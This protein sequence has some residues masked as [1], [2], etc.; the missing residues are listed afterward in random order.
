MS[1]SL[2]GLGTFWVSRRFSLLYPN[3]W[4]FRNLF[5]IIISFSHTFFSD[6]VLLPNSGTVGGVSG[7][8]L[9]KLSRSR[10]CTL[11]NHFVLNYGFV[12]STMEQP[13]LL[14]QM[15]RS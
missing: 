9:A 10:D 4:A 14:A 5:P 11:I 7:T 1:S 8:Y 6:T 3:F 13:S 15:S 12:P 2:N